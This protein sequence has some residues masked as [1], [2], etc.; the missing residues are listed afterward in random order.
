MCVCV[1]VCVNVIRLTLH[2]QVAVEVWWAVTVQ[3]MDFTIG[4][5]LLI[6]VHITIMLII[7]LH[8]LGTRDDGRTNREEGEGI[9]EKINN[10]AHTSKH[11]WTLQTGS[12][13]N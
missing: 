1:C 12:G 2:V 5:Q 7:A 8:I 11:V 10:E 3:H 9:R 4:G 13:F 6:R